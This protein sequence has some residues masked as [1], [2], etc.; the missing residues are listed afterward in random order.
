[1]NFI[2][3]APHTGQH[4]RAITD[5][6]GRLELGPNRTNIHERKGPQTRSWDGNS[7]SSLCALCVGL[8]LHAVPVARGCRVGAICASPCR[9]TPRGVL[10][11]TGR[12]TSV[13]LHLRVSSAR[14]VARRYTDPASVHCTIPALHVASS[15]SE[16]VSRSLARSSGALHPGVDAMRKEAGTTVFSNYIS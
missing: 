12:L 16:N 5:V 13:P 4:G 6:C 8:S 11:R 2:P 3:H 7:S 1:M 15:R 14:A 10:R 9:A